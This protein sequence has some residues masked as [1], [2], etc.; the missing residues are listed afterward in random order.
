MLV[1]GMI[2]WIPY[3]LAWWL[4]DGFN[5]VLRPYQADYW[6]QDR[7]HQRALNEPGMGFRTGPEGYGLYSGHMRID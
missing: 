4:S 1:G 6:E 2:F 5:I 3:W 7:A